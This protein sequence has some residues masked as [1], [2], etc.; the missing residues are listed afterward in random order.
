M[1]CRRWY[2]SQWEVLPTLSVNVSCGKRQYH[3]I[4]QV[5]AT[6]TLMNLHFESQTACTF[7]P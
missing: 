7:I 1:H 4:H 6:E 5:P 3:W 2:T